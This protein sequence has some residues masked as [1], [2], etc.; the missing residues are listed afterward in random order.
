MT[1]FKWKNGKLVS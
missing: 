1:D